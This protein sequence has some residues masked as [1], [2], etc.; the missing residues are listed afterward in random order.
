MLG[1]NSGWLCSCCMNAERQSR[2]RHAHTG[3]SPAR[4]APPLPEDVPP[5]PSPPPYP[6]T[7][8]NAGDFP[9]LVNAE[10]VSIQRV[11]TKA[12]EAHLRGLIEAHVERTGE[13]GKE[14]AARQEGVA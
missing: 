2:G 5:P 6:P 1:Q 13:R 10:I 12:G 11:Q 8:P 14:A 4:L 3:A 7:H 9:S